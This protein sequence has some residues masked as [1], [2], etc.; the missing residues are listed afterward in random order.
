MFKYT[1]TTISSAMTVMSFL[2]A[3]INIPFLL[4][5]RVLNLGAFIFCTVIGANNLRLTI[6][7]F[8]IEK[9]IKFLEDYDSQHRHDADNDV[10]LSARNNG[11]RKLYP[12]S[13][14]RK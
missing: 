12:E 1:G 9:R 11:G 13:F 4:E 5:G 2:F 7:T 3:A 14:R 6:K 10:I 8:R